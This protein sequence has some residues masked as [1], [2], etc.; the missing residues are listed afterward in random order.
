MSDARTPEEVEAAE[1]AGPA[2]GQL[3][4]MPVP[5]RPETH[6]GG[7]AAQSLKD[8]TGVKRMPVPK[9]TKPP[10]RVTHERWG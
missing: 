5:G 9:E 6:H 8:Q 4:K 1:I 3:R 7:T 10:Q 2:S